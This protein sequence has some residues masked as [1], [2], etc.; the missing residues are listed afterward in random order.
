M[1]KDGLRDY[2]G[3]CN[4]TSLYSNVQPWAPTYVDAVHRAVPPTYDPRP[5]DTVKHQ[6]CEPISQICALTYDAPGKAISSAPQVSLKPVTYNPEALPLKTYDSVG[7]ICA[8]T[9]DSSGREIV[10]PS[11]ETPKVSYSTEG[12]P[13][14][15]YEPNG[16]ICATTYD[17]SGL[18]IRMTLREEPESG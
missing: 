6:L 5:V 9:Y 15:S 4:Y 11:V 17:S 12:R 1:E 16:Q 7:H 8:M 13:S 10:S 14:N 2:L 3:Q 18:G